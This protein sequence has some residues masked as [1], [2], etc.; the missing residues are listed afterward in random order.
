MQNFEQNVDSLLM[1]DPNSTDPAEVAIVLK[2]TFTGND[3][4]PG[5]KKH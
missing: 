5:F 1:G 4:G 3:F 2:I